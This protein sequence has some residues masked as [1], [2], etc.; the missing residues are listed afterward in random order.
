MK[1]KIPIF[2]EPFDLSLPSGLKIHPEQQEILNQIE[3][4]LTESFMNDVIEQMHKFFV[5]GQEHILQ[6]LPTM[7]QLGAMTQEQYDQLQEDSPSTESSADYINYLLP[8]F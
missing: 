1:F 2:P 6:M 7:I 4:K 3:S 5:E 8:P